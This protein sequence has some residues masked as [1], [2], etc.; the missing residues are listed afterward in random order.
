MQNYKKLL[1]LLFILGIIFA[2]FLLNSRSKSESKPESVETV[3]IKNTKEKAPDDS[4]SI[5]EKL[6]KNKAELKKK[7]QVFIDRVQAFNPDPGVDAELITINLEHCIMLLNSDEEPNVSYKT[8][9]VQ[10][11]FQ[12]KYKQ[13]LNS[14]CDE[15][16]DKHP[17]YLL[18]NEDEIKVL[19]DTL[20][21]DNE[22]GKLLN[23]FYKDENFDLET[24]D[25]AS[26]IKHLKNVNPNLL[27]NAQRYLHSYFG[28]HFVKKI[29]AMIKSSDRDYIYNVKNS[30]TDLY[31]CNAGANCDRLSNMMSFYC[32]YRNL[33]GDDFNDILNNK[34]SEGIRLDILKVHEY[35]Q[36][37]FK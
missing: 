36:D 23:N 13:D 11:D 14:Y 32:N 18:T 6:K 19:R 15:I 37:S 5:Q 9:N 25:I 3:S 31:A 35:M 17:E 30:A 2:Y 29:G 1:I 16:N 22:I 21:S 7:N 4:L 12:V 8:I 26:K 10:S 27:L 24:F 34:M 33:C 28:D 20:T